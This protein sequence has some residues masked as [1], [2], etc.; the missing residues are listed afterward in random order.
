MLGMI[1]KRTFL[2]VFLCIFVLTVPII[3]MG[4]TPPAAVPAAADPVDTQ[5]PAPVETGVS[6]EPTA[7]PTPEPDLPMAARVNGEGLLLREYEAELERFT[8]AMT[9]LGKEIEPDAQR[10][11]VLNELV[12][13]LLLAQ[14][15]YAA[16]FQME[17]ADLDARIA[18][19][20]DP[21]TIADWQSRHNYDTSS[22]RTAMKRQ[23][24]A[25]WQRDQIAGS[26][27]DTI[28]QVQAR[29]ILVFDG[30]LAARLHSRLRDG[31]EFATLARQIDPTGG[32]LGW[33]PRGYLLLPEIESAAFAQQPGEYSEVI[34][35]AYGY[36]IVQ[37]VAYEANHAVSADVRRF[38]QHKALQAWIEEQRS[39]SQVEVYLP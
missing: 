15:A 29:H 30:D 33:F 25:A 27:P 7:V 8:A 31:A 9:E 4:C 5:L 3:L 37:T 13:Q 38:L 12:D 11:A 34:E 28:E 2:K 22:F 23:A 10:E 20:G 14:A 19:L 16:G 36:H 1:S 24:A 39:T 26:V 18:Q 6:D 35:T 21:Q 17:D 32:E